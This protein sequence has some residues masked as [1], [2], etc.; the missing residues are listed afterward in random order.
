MIV[1]SQLLLRQI[2]QVWRADA[3]ISLPPIETWIEALKNSFTLACSTE[4]NEIADTL[5]LLE[6]AVAEVVYQA[7]DLRCCQLFFNPTSRTRRVVGQNVFL[8]AVQCEYDR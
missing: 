1:G 4:D 7:K 6:A 5:N 8:V 2:L 3:A